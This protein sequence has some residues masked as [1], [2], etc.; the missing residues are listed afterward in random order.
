MDSTSFLLLLY[1]RFLRLDVP[2]VLLGVFLFRLAGSKAY[3]LF[4]YPY[5]VSPLRHLPGPKN[6][7]FLIGHTLNQ[8]RSGH[9]NEPFVSWMRRW[10]K[11][12]LIRYFDV[13]NAD[14]VLVTSLEAHKEIL[15][16]KVYSFQK[17]PFFVRLIADIVGF[18]IGF[19]E[20]DEHKKQRR[21]L[22]MKYPQECLPNSPVLFSTKNLEGFI[23]LLR[24]K[25]SHLSHQLDDIIRTE[26]GVVDIVSLYSKITLDIMGQFAIGRELDEL[27]GQSGGDNSLASMP[28]HAC[29]RELFEPDG[30][31]QLLIAINGVFPIRWLPLKANRRFNQAHKTLRSQIQAVIQERIRALDPDKTGAAT[32]AS[33]N[34]G[35]VHHG[36]DENSNETKDLLSWMVSR[37]YYADGGNNHRDRWGEDEIRDQILTFLAAGHQ[38]TADALT[39]ATQ[40]MIQHPAEAQRLRAEVVDLLRRCGTHPPS[41]RDIETLHYLHNFTREVLRVQ[42]PGINVAREAIHDVVVQGVLIPKGTTVLMQ[43]AIIHKNPTIWG[44]DCDE[45]RPDRWDSLT[46]GSEAA[47][48]WAFAA[49]SHGPR[50]CIGRAFSMLEFKV[51]LIELV[52]RFRFDGLGRNGR[53]AHEIKLVNPSPMLRPDGGLK[54]RV[55]RAM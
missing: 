38:T 23:P 45:F 2:L 12:P 50:I 14:A 20:G 54:V 35:S 1:D 42:C 39:W 41:C 11:T 37:K 47:D 18:G 6:H 49:F 24:S 22:A 15:H 8:F 4:I 13:G 7:H 46:P 27:T 48:P 19:A 10:P 30:V 55:E 33:I 9:P 31:G 25:A 26:G 51:L 36:S 44:A 52:S 34:R 17:P 3:R 16:A 40:L 21:A 29:Y 43:P 32:A 53:M 5:F 28:F